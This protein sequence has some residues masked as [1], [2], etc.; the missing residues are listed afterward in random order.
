MFC[1][2]SQNNSLNHIQK[3]ALRLLYD[4]HMESFQ[5]KKLYI[6]NLERLAK[7]IYKF[8]YGLSPPAINDIFKVGGNI[9]NLAKKLKSGTETISYRDPQIRNLISDSIQNVSSLKNFKIWKD[10]S[11]YGK[12]KSAHV[13]IVI[14]TCKT[15]ASSKST[16]IETQKSW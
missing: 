14:N 9:C 10:N 5:D 13:G 3:R 4:D 7:E 11:K 1:L 12:A 2:R 8:I 6:K 16:D 15:S